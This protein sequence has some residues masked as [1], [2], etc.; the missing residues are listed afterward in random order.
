M[1]VG[2]NAHLLSGRAGYRSAGIHSYISN[3]LRHLPMQAPADWGF[4][5]LVGAANSASFPGVSMARAG[6]DT[7]QP[8]RRMFLGAGAAALATAALRPVSRD[9]LCR[10]GDFDRAD[11]RHRL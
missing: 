4:E 3:L 1:R 5:A 10:A 9:G 6:M 11:G 8:W 2:L 7:E